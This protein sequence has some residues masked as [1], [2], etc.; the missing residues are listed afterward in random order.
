MRS[1][2]AVQSLGAWGPQEVI[3]FARDNSALVRAAVVGELGK[4]AN[5]DSA[6]VLSELSVDRTLEVQLTAVRGPRLA[7]R[8]GVSTSAARDAR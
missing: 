8:I 1:A 6:V 7:R 4:S 2:I 3:P 5:L